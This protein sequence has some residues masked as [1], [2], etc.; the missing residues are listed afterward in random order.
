MAKPRRTLL[1]HTNDALN[2]LDEYWQE[3][4]RLWPELARRLHSSE[5]ELYRAARWA[6]TAHDWGKASRK[7]QGKIVL[8]QRPGVFHAPFSA[9]FL[10]LSQKAQAELG[11]WLPVVVL[12]VMSHHSQLHQGSLSGDKI[13][14]MGNVDFYEQELARLWP[15]LKG[16]PGRISGSECKELAESLKS[17]VLE[18]NR[19]GEKLLLKARYCWLHALLRWLDN[20]ASR[21]EGFYPEEK[22]QTA[23]HSFNQN[24]NKWQKQTNA[25]QEQAAATTAPFLVIQGGCGSGKTGAAL[26]WAEKLW[27]EGKCE[28]IIFTLP[29]QFTSN[30]LY[31]DLSEKYGFPAGATGIY[32]SDIDSVLRQ[33]LEDEEEIEEVRYFNTFYQKPINVSTVDHLLY[34]L[35]H[36]YRY[37]DRAFG[38]LMTAAVVFDE[39][40]YYDQFTLQKIGQATSFLRTLGIPHAIMSA[41]IPGVMR[42]QLQKLGYLVLEQEQEELP[43]E[44]VKAREEMVSA[45]EVNQ[46]LLELVA[47]N[48][49]CKQMIV[50]NQVERAKKIART[51]AAQFPEL[52]VI[53]YHS[54]FT[55]ADRQEKEQLI[56]RRFR[57]NKGGVVL[58]STQVCELSLDISADVMY[59]ELAPADA[60]IQRFGRMHRRGRT[61]WREECGCCYCAER[62]YLPDDFRY[63]AYIFPVDWRE[64]RTTLPYTAGLLQLTWEN[65]PVAF[66]YTEGKRWVDAVYQVLPRLENEDMY[67]MVLEDVVFGRTPRERYGD[68]EAETSQGA[69]RVR[70]SEVITVPT[71]PASLWDEKDYEDRVIQVS[72]GKIRRSKL[73]CQ[74]LKGVCILNNPYDNKFGYEFNV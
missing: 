74:W 47:K 58:V 30:S 41:T 60:L 44:I 23:V 29:T 14:G 1:D 4:R 17:Y 13:S 63:R 72:L 64:P 36:S 7:F 55:R 15:E 39:I 11:D 73:E 9:Y 33:E 70:H 22:S 53:C 8:N 46:E 26:L 5:P 37:A 48:R 34:S 32:H 51:L 57:D 6:L 38:N 3:N 68:E 12:A 52:E 20:L 42:E 31:W 66:S 10:A 18:M 61:P 21:G 25:I 59:T 50:V 43:L 49:E 28:R 16:I 69:F 45:G 2:L 71:V 27:Q 67:R 19:P 65:I 56:R 24:R 54:E 35:L 40:H 62:V